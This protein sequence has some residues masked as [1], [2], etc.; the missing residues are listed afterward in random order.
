M[1]DVCP[2]YGRHFIWLTIL[3]WVCGKQRYARPRSRER[4]ITHIHQ[5]KVQNQYRLGFVYR[6]S[7]IEKQEIPS[8]EFARQEAYESVTEDVKK[9]TAR[10]PIVTG[11]KN[12]HLRAL[13]YGF[14]NDVCARCYGL[15]ISGIEGIA[16]PRPILEHQGR[17]RLCMDSS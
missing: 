1:I 5:M 16:M 11:R 9:E 3:N 7:R 8:R 2:E 4:A 14:E 15:L 17:V 10:P 13:I 6:Q 12:L